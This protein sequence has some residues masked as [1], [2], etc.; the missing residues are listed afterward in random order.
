MQSGVEARGSL[1]PLPLPEERPSLYF[2]LADGADQDGRISKH[3]FHKACKLGLV[4]YTLR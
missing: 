2:K 1:R 3:E 4:K